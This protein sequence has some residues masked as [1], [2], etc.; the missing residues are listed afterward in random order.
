MYK[1]END[2]VRIGPEP[3]ASNAREES[4]KTNAPGAM[5]R[6]PLQLP[7][8]AW[9]QIAGRMWMMWGFHN[10]SLLGAGVAFFTF[11]AIAPLIAST[12]MIY[13]LVGDVQTVRE[14][15]GEIVA[16][17]PA[18]VASVIEGQLV[19]AVTTSASVTGIALFV[20]L[21]FAF[22]GAMRAANGMIGALN[23]I[24]E[25]GET[26][27]II[28]VTGQAAMLTLAAIFIALAGLLS[29]GVFA[30]LELQAEFVLGRSTVVIAEILLWLTAFSLG[31]FGFAIVMRYGPDRTPAQW[32]WLAPGA[33]LATVL[34]IA[35]SFG[36][37]YYVAYISDYSATYGSLSAIVVLLMW[38][39]LSAYGL[40]A[41]ALL[42]A[43]I[44]RQTVVDT[45]VGPAK[46]LGERG[47]VL[48]DLAEGGL[49]VQQW[50]EKAERRSL[51]R[52][53]RAAK[54]KG[55]LSGGEM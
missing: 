29:G 17:V 46:P 37:S 8:A 16:I 52:R 30:W 26:R 24:N 1:T 6:H 13:G 3:V 23:V 43:E 31:S 35:V 22:Y 39:F 18:D 48:A 20:A 36:F 10:L 40:L 42:N 44:E 12:V 33:L 15:M 34:W 50:L 38:L 45:T 9:K 2:P 28:R 7:I 54:I 14:Q 21:A 25:E 53:T 5:A 4:S 27:G 47:A 11:L 19:A 49:S 51:R 55:L 41:G 32:K